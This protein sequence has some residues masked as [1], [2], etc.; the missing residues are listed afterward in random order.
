MPWNVE[1]LVKVRETIILIH[2]VEEEEI[3]ISL[4]EIWMKKQIIW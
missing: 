2:I 4:P 1:T 3:F